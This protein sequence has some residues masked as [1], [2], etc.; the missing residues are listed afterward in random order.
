MATIAHKEGLETKK[1]SPGAKTFFQAKLR[2]NTPGDRFEQEADAVAEKIVSMPER[3]S[4]THGPITGGLYNSPIDIRR[5]CAECEEEEEVQM[6][7]YFKGGHADRDV[8]N[9]IQ[10]EI[11]GGNPMASETRTWMESKFGMGFGNVRIHDNANSQHLNR[12]LNAKAFTHGDHIFFNSGEYSPHS[13][14]G[15][16][17]LAH[18]LTHVVQ[19][20][21][22]AGLAEELDKRVGIGGNMVQRDLMVA[23]PNPNAEPAELTEAEIQ[24]AI[25]F[26]ERRFHDPYNI[27]NVRD[28]IGIDQYP[29]VIDQEFVEAVA[30]W[31]AMFDMTQDGKMGAET[32]QTILAELNAAG[33]THEAETLAV[34]NTVSTVDVVPRTYNTCAPGLPFEFNWQVGF[35]TTMRNGFIIQRIDNTFN[36]TM[37]DGTAYTGWTPIRRYWEAWSVDGAGN[38]RPVIGG[39]N[40]MFTRP[41]IAGSR[42]NWVMRGTLYTTRTLPASFV[43][44]A[45][46]DAGILRATLTDPG[47]DFLGYVAA[48]RRV[49]GTWDCCAATPTHVAS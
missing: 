10:S 48:T 3:R 45:V 6:K 26:N 22:M 20:G 41:L 43:A 19:Q 28:V 38:V 13:F 29:A 27:M 24:A 39:V 32:T 9:G 49:G 34:D 37:C 17:L 35:R 18:E 16:K 7:G 12:K 44:S 46:A 23:P 47:N 36:G 15:K 4:A 8:E 42:G 40:D 21:G 31:Q 1:H 33:A 11:Q 25:T 2:V 14:Q 5:K 30:R